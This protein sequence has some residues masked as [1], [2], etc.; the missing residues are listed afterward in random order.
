MKKIKLCPNWASSDHVLDRIIKQFKTP[1]ID[2]SNIQ[3]VNDNSYDIIVYFNYV[4][5]SPVNNKK[6]Y[7]FPNEPY[8]VGNHQ[9]DVSDFPNA[10]IFGFDCSKYKG[11]C[12][13]CVMHMV[14]GG[15]GPPYD[16]TDFW[17]FENLSQLKTD[18]TKIMS[19]AITKKQ[20]SL[21][22]SCLYPQRYNL[23]KNILD[24]NFID[25]F[26]GW[27]K[28]EDKKTAL[29]DYYFSIGIENE[30]SP[31]LIT[32]KFYDCILT[33]TIPIYYGCSNITDIYP[34]KGYILIEDINDIDKIKKQLLD[35]RNNYQDIYN[36]LIDKTI[37]I[38]NKL[39]TKYNLLKKIVE[40]PS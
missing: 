40:L 5:E 17:N 11:H 33:N 3:F 37:Q 25:F 4:S 31:N 21:A 10:T 34:E 38:K 35:I 20:D 8:W 29:I 12:E 23:V 22:D 26:G 24:F 27:S 1:D 9:K 14:Y 36:S 2:L 13:E 30:R 39:F 7:I 19:C 32:E 15:Q 28:F 18:K 16:N 6:A